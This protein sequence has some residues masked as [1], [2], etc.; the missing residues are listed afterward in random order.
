MPWPH[1]HGLNFFL[2]IFTFDHLS[3]VNDRSLLVPEIDLQMD[4]VR[5]IG[6]H[7]ADR[8]VD[9]LAKRQTHLDAITYLVGCLRHELGKSNPVASNLQLR[10]LNKVTSITQEFLHGEIYFPVKD[11]ACDRRKSTRESCLALHL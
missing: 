3:L 11:C 7:R 1:L 8:S 4:A 6:D 5:P 9:D 10:T 2:F